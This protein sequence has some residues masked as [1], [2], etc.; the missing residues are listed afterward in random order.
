MGRIIENSI[1]ESV[2]SK[3]ITHPSLITKLYEIAGV[4]I[5]EN[6]DKCPPMQ[7]LHFPQKKT[8]CLSRHNIFERATKE[9]EEWDDREEEN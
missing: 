4:K 1:L 8:T 3:A 5:I 6:E 9:R 2:Y 7:P